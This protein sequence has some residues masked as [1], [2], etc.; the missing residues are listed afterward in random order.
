MKK[1]EHLCDSCYRATNPRAVF[2]SCS[3][4]GL[5]DNGDPKLQIPEGVERSEGGR[6][7]SCPL[8]LSDEDGR[9]LYGRGELL[10]DPKIVRGESAGIFDGLPEI[11][12]ELSFAHAGPWG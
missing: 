9:E 5:D 6:F 1:E 7:I 2:N 10:L 3:W 12:L 4:S 8:Y 11:S